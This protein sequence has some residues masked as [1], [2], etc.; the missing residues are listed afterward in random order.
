MEKLPPKI[1]FLLLGTA[2]VLLIAC[3]VLLLFFLIRGRR[4]PEDPAS[5]DWAAAY[6]DGSWKGLRYTGGCSLS[7]KGSRIRFIGPSHAEG[8]YL[9]RTGPLLASHRGRLDFTDGGPYEYLIYHEEEYNGQT[10]RLISCVMMEYDGRGEVITEEYIPE[11]QYSLVPPNFLSKLAER[12]N[13][14]P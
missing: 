10:L 14:Q 7:V 11:E 4:A 1:R 9:F 12:M 8:S 13:G 5:R 3:L 6:L 2:G